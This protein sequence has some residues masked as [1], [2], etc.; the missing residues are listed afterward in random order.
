MQKSPTTP[1]TPA[2]YDAYE[3]DRMRAWLQRNP[4][5]AAMMQTPVPQG[6]STAFSQ[7]RALRTALWRLETRDPAPDLETWRQT[8]VALYWCNA[9][10]YAVKGQSKDVLGSYRFLASM[11]PVRAWR[12]PAPPTRSR[13]AEPTPPTGAV[14]FF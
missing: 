4:G 12:S 9:Y 5:A 14:M 7:L 3:V 1:W 2:H 11:R 6:L 8:V 10:I 13:A